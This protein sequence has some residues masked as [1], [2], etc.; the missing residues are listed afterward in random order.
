MATGTG[1]AR[2]AAGVTP[3]G[4][5]PGPRLDVTGRPVTLRQVDLDTFFNPRRV[6]VVGASDAEGRPNTSVTRKVT[7][8]AER[9]G[10]TVHYVNPNRAEVAGRPALRALTDIGEEL[11]LVAILVGD[12]LPVLRDAVAAGAR[13][14]VVFSAGFAEVG[15]EGRLLQDEME[16]IV[17]GSGLHLLGPNTNLNAFEAFRHDLPGPAIAL[18]TQSGHQGRPVFQGQELGIKLSHWAPA[19]NE[20]D[21]E[22]ADFID[23]F[24]GLPSTGAVACYIEGFKDGRTLQ[25]AAD[26]AA[27]RKVPV[28]VVKV[29]RTDAG[30]S[31]AKAHTGHLTGSDA[32]ISAVFGQY[33]IQRVDGLDQLLE[34]SAALA[35]TKPPAPATLRRLT[36]GAGG[37]VCVYSISGGT[38]AHM[39]DLAAAAGLELPPL[40]RSSRAQL[41][42]WIPSYLRVSNPVDSGGPPVA[43]WRGARIL[44]TILS[45]PNVDL[46]LCPITGAVPAMGDQLCADLVAAADRSDKPV[47][48]IWGSP[49]GTEEAYTKTLLGSTVPTFRTF[50]NAVLAAKAYFD[51]HRFAASYRSAFSRPALRPSPAKRAARPLLAPGGAPRPSGAALSEQD[52]KALLATYGMAVPAE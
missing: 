32:V 44:E 30:T 29:G 26:A 27:R 52:A 11:D 22:A 24:S 34:T 13:F 6:A 36:R 3:S 15:A 25:L 39:A 41:H 42:Q 50:G 33:G 51:H 2:A 18:V 21:L 8:W 14:A 31:M 38:G 19:G 23:Y 7:A 35:R 5:R 46:L 45:D 20:A 47:F 4:L 17:A 16:R 48:V 49:V 1:A 37:R 40:A 43:D 10:A 12:P 9:C 28:V